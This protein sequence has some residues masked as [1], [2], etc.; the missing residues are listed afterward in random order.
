M[1]VLAIC[2]HCKNQFLSKMI[3]GERVVLENCR[4]ECP[5]CRGMADILNGEYI[6][7]ADGVLTEIRRLNLAQVQQ[8]RAVLSRE[9]ERNASPEEIIEKVKQVAPEVGAAM[10]TAGEGKIIM[11]ALMIFIYILMNRL[12]A[13]GPLISM[14]RSE[15]NNVWNISLQSARLN[16]A[17]DAGE[18]EEDRDSEG[19]SR[20]TEPKTS[21]QHTEVSLRDD[22]YSDHDDENPTKS[23]K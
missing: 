9:R 15:I 16:E 19:A 10:E 3:S 23:R 14:D 21:P 11:A 8:I 4:V 6:H 7:S 5:R 20:K 18:N 12:S 13:G 17:D 1:P 22:A 2:P